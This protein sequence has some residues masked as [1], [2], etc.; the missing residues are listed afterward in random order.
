MHNKNIVWQELFVKKS[1]R[2]QIKNH[3]PKCICFTGL[4]GAGKTTIATLLE[5]KLLEKASI[6]IC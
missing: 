2:H 3:T 5:K 4:S 6:H 1:D